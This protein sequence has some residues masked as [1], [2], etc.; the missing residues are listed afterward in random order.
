MPAV[1]EDR[2]REMAASCAETGAKAAEMV[3]QAEEFIPAARRAVRRGVHAYGDLKEE[4]LH[5][6]K[7]HPVRSVGAA[8][9][10]GL[11]AGWG[12]SLVRRLFR[13][14]EAVPAK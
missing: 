1:L 12:V 4:A 11:V 7:S 14:T 3:R 2:I 10:A 5:E 6:V 13:R 9:A 8:F